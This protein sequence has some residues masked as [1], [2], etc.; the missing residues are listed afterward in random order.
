[1][2]SLPKPDMKYS[3]MKATD[4]LAIRGTPEFD[5]ECRRQATALAESQSSLA[6]K[7][8]EEFCNGDVPGW[9]YDA[10]I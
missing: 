5:A 7:L 2:A 6:A 3:A 4:L 10:E 9:T 1:M 8:A